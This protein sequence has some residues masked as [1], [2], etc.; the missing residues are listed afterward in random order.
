MQHISQ[1]RTKVGVTVPISPSRRA[2]NNRWDAQHMATL[3]VRMRRE[4]ADAVR[5]AAASAGQS[6]SAYILDA[7][8]E[9]MAREGL[10][11]DATNDSTSDC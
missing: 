7:I 5:A 9:R 1:F 4:R 8:R 2:A 11:L 10:T 3:G 6:V